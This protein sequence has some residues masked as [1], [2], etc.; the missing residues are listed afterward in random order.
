M[1]VQLKK[2]VLKPGMI[3]EEEASEPDSSLSTASSPMRDDPKDLDYG[4]V[5][6]K[7]MKKSGGGVPVNHR[8]YSLPTRRPV[9][10]ASGMQTVKK[11][12]GRPPKSRTV[13]MVPT[14]TEQQPHV[15][16]ATTNTGLEDMPQLAPEV[17]K[18]ARG[19]PRTVRQLVAVVAV[20]RQHH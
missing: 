12:R 2:K 20:L 1:A 7:K 17:I 8:T 18:K 6:E 10:H 5:L 16:V 13:S 19:R 14:Q 15:V 4:V 11:P 3:E 9:I